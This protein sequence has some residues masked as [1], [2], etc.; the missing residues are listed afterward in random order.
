MK[1]NILIE[2]YLNYCIFE[3]G[4]SKNTVEAYKNDLKLYI[5]FL[6]KPIEEVSTIDI[7]NYIKKRHEYSSKTIA[8]NLTVIKNFHTYL[9]E[10][11]HLKQNPT[12]NIQR[13]KTKKTLPKTLSKNQINILMDI[14]LNTIFDYRNKAM[15]EVMYSSG[16]RVSELINLKKTS[17]NYEEQTIKI[18]GKGS[19]ERIVPIN[20]KA[21]ECLKIYLNKRKEKKGEFIFLNNKNKP[22]SRN[23]FYKILKKILKEK[24]L[25][26]IASP[27]SLRHSFATH[28]INNGA[29][30]RSVQTILGHTDITTTKIYTE[31]DNKIVNK[32]YNQ[33]H[34]RSKE[35]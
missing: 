21:L 10:K 19:K 27:H 25:P 13:P 26:D 9:Y 31:I 20:K 1:I 11:K 28:I 6:N 35:N 16:I 32:E 12:I 7:K 22:I 30:L 5:N 8:H 34:P 14:K 3:L 33:Y 17:I 24:N 18:M 23:G 15:L 4:L 29:D 2:D